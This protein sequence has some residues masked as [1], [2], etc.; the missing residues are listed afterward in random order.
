MTIIQGGCLCG[1]VR[2]TATAEPIATRACWCRV[3]QY[4]ATG[5]ASLNLVFAREAVAVTG[6]TTDYASLAD[7]GN[8]MHRHFC[9]SCGVQVYSLVDERP[10]LVILR[11]GTLDDPSLA[12]PR[13]TIW[14][15]SAPPWALIDP[16]LPR[17]EGQPPPV[18]KPGGG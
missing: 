8:H 5:N 13:G 4:F 2:Y 1:A 15:K 10:H 11:V 9:P 14:T 17:H 3:C 18:P 12:A 7:S 16:A 6:A